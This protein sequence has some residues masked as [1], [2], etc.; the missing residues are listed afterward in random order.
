MLC[1][2][3]AL[4]QTLRLSP[5]QG[6]TVC[7]G[8]PRDAGL[9]QAFACGLSAAAR[10]S[11]CVDALQEL[12]PNYTRTRYTSRTP[13]RDGFD[14][15]YRRRR[16]AAHDPRSA[17]GDRVRWREWWVCAVRE[18]C[19]AGPGGGTRLLADRGRRAAGRGT[20]ALVGA[21]LPTNETVKACACKARFDPADPHEE[22]RPAR[23]RNDIICSS[24]LPISAWITRWADRDRRPNCRPASQKQAT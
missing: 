14:R 13:R 7:S 6:L 9:V 5:G 22:A 1:N 11:R 23:I 16:Q 10:Y 2:A 8:C 18:R 21:V 15:R 19:L 12:S 4:V 3:P 24:T 17:F 20:F